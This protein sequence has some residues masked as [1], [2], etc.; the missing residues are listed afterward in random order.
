MQHALL[1]YRIA[2]TCG[3]SVV[4]SL[5]FGLFRTPLPDR[6]EHLR[7]RMRELKEQ[8]QEHLLKFAE[9]GDDEVRRRPSAQRID[10]DVSRDPPPPVPDPN[11]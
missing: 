8:M 4:Q 2:R 9:L 11:A 10:A 6:P 7:L 3:Y 5:R 1:F